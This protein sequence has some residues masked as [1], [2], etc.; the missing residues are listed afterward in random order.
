MITLILIVFKLFTIDYKLD[1]EG[2]LTKNSTQEN[3]LDISNGFTVVMC[4][5]VDK[6]RVSK[7][8][9]IPYKSPVLI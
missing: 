8:S 9:Q 7:L 2:P 3:D 1:L 4:N 6:C 5:R